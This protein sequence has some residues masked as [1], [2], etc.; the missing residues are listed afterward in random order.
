MAV[1]NRFY[2]AEAKYVAA[3]GG[4]DFTEV[5]ALLDPEVVL[6]QAPGLPFTGTGTWRG[7][8][9]IQSFFDRFSELWQ[10]MDVIDA[11]SV[12]DGDT[13]V[14]LLHVRF[15]ARTTGRTVD[16]RIAQV[17][18]ITNGRISEFRPYYWNPSAITKACS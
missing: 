7:H 5:A 2:A 12:V 4:T 8:Q 1:M 17:N 9:G 10:S 6:Y 11:R 13:V 18:T 14:M 15:R 16:T 3:A